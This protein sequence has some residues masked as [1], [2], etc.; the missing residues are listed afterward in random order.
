MNKKNKHNSK[1]PFVWNVLVPNIF[2]SI[3]THLQW[4]TPN[5]QGTGVQHTWR[6]NNLGLEHSEKLPNQFGGHLKSSNIPLRKEGHYNADSLRIRGISRLPIAIRPLPLL[7]SSCTNPHTLMAS[8]PSFWQVGE[9][10]AHTIG[11]HLIH[12]NCWA[13]KI[14][15]IIIINN[16]NNNAYPRNQ[17]LFS[18][19]QKV[20]KSL[21]SNTKK[22][23]EKKAPTLG[24]HTCVYGY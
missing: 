11:L 1:H 18:K 22:N 4:S 15:I 24:D 12:Y 13:R 7:R 20:I 5:F 17:M 23:K 16:N 8:W 9:G 19:E 10:D 21:I 3:L 14:L 6:P 2:L